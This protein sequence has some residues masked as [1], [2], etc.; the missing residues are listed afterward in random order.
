M[1]A[2]ELI[3]ELIEIVNREG[4][5]QVFANYD[6]AIAGIDFN[7]IDQ[8]VELYSDCFDAE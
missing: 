4:D 7:E 8:C 1:M 2:S 6:L 5:V 3:T